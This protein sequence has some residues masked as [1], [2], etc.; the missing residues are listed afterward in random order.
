VI[1]L[2]DKVSE[3]DILDV[4]VVVLVVEVD[5]LDVDV[6]LVVKVEVLVGWVVV[7][8]TVIYT[9]IFIRESVGSRIQETV[10]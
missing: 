10:L 9:I 1:V 4:D 5:V 3:V 2:V 6:E 8:G 7:L